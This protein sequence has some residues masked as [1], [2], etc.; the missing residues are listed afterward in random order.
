MKQGRIAV[1]IG[2]ALALAIIGAGAS[3]PFAHAAAK[4]ASSK[5][6]SARASRKSAGLHQFSGVVTAVDK[7]SLTVEKNGKAPK[8]MTFARHAGMTTQGDLERDAR[9]TV[10]YRD[11]DG[12]SVAHKVVVK[13]EAAPAA[14]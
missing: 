1:A 3:P 9:V 6:T 11:E 8:S 10:F 5:S 14:K 12:R 7:A 2:L 13:G 4:S